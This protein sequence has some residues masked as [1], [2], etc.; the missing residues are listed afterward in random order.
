MSDEYTIIAWRPLTDTFT[1][2]GVVGTKKYCYEMS[3]KLQ[4]E[5]LLADRKSIMRFRNIFLVV[6]KRESDD[7]AE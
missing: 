4:D 2:T 6:K 3:E 7:V 5:A 1:R